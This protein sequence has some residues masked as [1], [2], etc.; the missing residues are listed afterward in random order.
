MEGG[1]DIAANLMSRPRPSQR[2]QG[3][4]ATNHKVREMTAGP[5]FLLAIL[6]LGVH[7]LFNAWVVLGAAVTRE[8]PLLARV[9]ILSA[10][11]GAV[12]EN[13]PWPCPLTVGETWCEAR[14]GMAPYQGSFLLHYL[15]V[16]VYPHIPPGLLRLGA[17]G[18]CLANLA[19]YAGRC[20][21]QRHHA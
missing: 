9:H 10:I 21:R 8:R 4:L 3:A 17:I 12:I 18:V 5:Y 20:R 14:A 1:V 6:V 15:D 2:R 7:V 16:L 19:I 13:A 11:Y